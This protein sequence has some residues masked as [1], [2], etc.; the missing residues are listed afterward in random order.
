MESLSIKTEKDG[1][2]DGGQPFSK[3]QQNQ[4]E[5]FILVVLQYGGVTVA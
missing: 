5:G 3:T 4:G 1:C 2:G